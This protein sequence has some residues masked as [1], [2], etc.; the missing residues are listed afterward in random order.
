ML[1][2]YRP[3]AMGAKAGIRMPCVGGRLAVVLPAL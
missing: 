2:V 3:L 1:Q